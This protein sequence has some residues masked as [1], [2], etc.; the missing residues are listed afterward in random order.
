[1]KL[2]IFE[3]SNL[4]MRKVKEMVTCKSERW[5]TLGLKSDPEG[6]SENLRFD[7]RY[8]NDCSEYF[9]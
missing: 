3:T 9:L 7:K 4:A 8:E 2:E 5:P 6:R 1:V